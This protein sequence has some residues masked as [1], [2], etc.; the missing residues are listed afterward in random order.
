MLFVQ[1]RNEWLNLSNIN[2]VFQSPNS[3]QVHFMSDDP[4]NVKQFGDDDAKIILKAIE[5]FSFKP[6][7]K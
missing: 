1:L 3:L 6:P 5:Q 7:E 2:Y 4:N